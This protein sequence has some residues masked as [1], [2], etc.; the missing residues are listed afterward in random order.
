MKDVTV[1]LYQNLQTLNQFIKEK[2]TNFE[3]YFLFL[4]KSFL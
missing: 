3:I 2:N 4:I 1:Y